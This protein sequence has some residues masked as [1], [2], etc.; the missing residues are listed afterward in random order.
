MPEGTAAGGISCRNP[1]R[2]SS[3]RQQDPPQRWFSPKVSRNRASHVVDGDSWV[4]NRV[5]I[6]TGHG[7]E[8]W[9]RV[10]DNAG[11]GDRSPRG[12]TRRIWLLAQPCPFSGSSPGCRLSGRSR[13]QQ[14]GFSQRS[15]TTPRS[16]RQPQSAHRISTLTRVVRCGRRL[17]QRPPNAGTGALA[18]VTCP[19]GDEEWSRSEAIGVHQQTVWRVQTTRCTVAP[20][21]HSLRHTV[22][23]TMSV[24]PPVFRRLFHHRGGRHRRSSRSRP[25]LSI[26]RPRR[27]V[28]S[29]DGTFAVASRA[30]WRS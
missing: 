11:S 2:S 27:V 6:G 8:A 21:E 24:F 1:G 23:K 12:P 30:P 22:S 29:H 14:S 19:V 15:T 3:L 10:P 7:C 25:G 5:G 9:G 18:E 16:T 20:S 13:Q 17:R 4:R 28:A 26:R